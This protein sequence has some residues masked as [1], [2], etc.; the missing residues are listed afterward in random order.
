MSSLSN[1]SATV[2]RK[3]SDLPPPAVDALRSNARKAN[4]I[5]PML[6]KALA[7]ERAGQPQGGQYWITCNR[8]SDVKFILAITQGYMG[9]YPA[10]IFTT[11]PFGELTDQKETI[12]PLI[13][14]LAEALSKAVPTKRIYSVF[15]VQPVAVIFAEEWTRIT[16]IQ[17]APSNPYYAAKISH[18]TQATLDTRST[19]DDA[20]QGYYLRRAVQADIPAI[21][22]LC[23]LFATVSVL[24]P[25]NFII[26]L[27]NSLTSLH[28]ACRRIERGKKQRYLFMISKYGSIQPG[29]KPRKKRLRRLWRAPATAQ[30]LA[31][32]QRS[33]LTLIGAAA[34]VP[35]ASSDVFANSNALLSWFT[36]IL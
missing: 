27:I 32:S 34:A 14:M 23:L 29:T 24:V 33:L 4:T 5:L 11:I 25:C 9:P 10:F 26:S 31:Q 13:S 36:D 35:N 17:P 6:D 18:C 30:Q 15:A 21:A 20:A 22:E 19:S 7:Q 1:L 2:Y 28:S 16:S 12:R 3:A 8:G